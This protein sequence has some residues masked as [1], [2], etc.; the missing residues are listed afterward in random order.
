MNGWIIF[1][2]YVVAWLIS[3]TLLT[4]RILIGIERDKIERFDHPYRRRLYSAAE[5]RRE[6]TLDRDDRGMA[7][8]GGYGLCLLVPVLPVLVVGAYDLLTTRTRIFHTPHEVAAERAE[9]DA[10]ELAE[11]RRLAAEFNLPT[12]ERSR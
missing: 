4:R 2:L 11:Y 8:F 3:G 5:I 7:V 12:P 6:T 1:A 10:A 9:R